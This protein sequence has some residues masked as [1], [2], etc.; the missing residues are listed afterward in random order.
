MKKAILLLSVWWAFQAGAQQTLIPGKT[1]ETWLLKNGYAECVQN[2][3]LDLSCARQKP[4]DEHNCIPIIQR[5]EVERQIAANLQQLNMP[6]GDTFTQGTPI[7]VRFQ[8]PL[9]SNTN[10]CQFY[11][12]NNYVDENSSASQFQDYRCGNRTYD[13][14]LGTDFT[15][16]PYSWYTMDH[17]LVQVVAA[18]PSTIV[19]KH[20]GEADR[21]C[22]GPTCRVNRQ[23]HCI[24]AQRWHAQLVFS[25]QSRNPHYLRR[26]QCGAGRRFLD[27]PAARVIHRGRTCILRCIMPGAPVPLPAQWPIRI[28]T[29]AAVVITTAIFRGG[30]IR[31]CMT[32]PCFIK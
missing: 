9:V 31:N 14:H 19:Y 6:S 22:A 30:I 4:Q 20:D 8:L 5:L 1:F 16:W 12:I 18:A 29:A 24:T 10:Q 28:M 3:Q 23:C 15:F 25:F 17:N 2:H 32:S 11:N 13:G 21:N 26:R 7:T 27:T